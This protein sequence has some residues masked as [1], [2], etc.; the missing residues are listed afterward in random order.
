MLQ[1]QSTT[2]IQPC[3]FSQLN[4]KSLL[5]TLTNV[6][7]LQCAAADA[8]MNASLQYQQCQKMHMAPCLCWPIHLLAPLRGPLCS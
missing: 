1:A 3:H 7:C 5:A 8:I 6:T 4:P 2:C